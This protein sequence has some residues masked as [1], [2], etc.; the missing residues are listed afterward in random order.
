M[1][2]NECFSHFHWEVI[3]KKKVEIAVMHRKVHKAGNDPNPI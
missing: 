1:H 3:D 2:D